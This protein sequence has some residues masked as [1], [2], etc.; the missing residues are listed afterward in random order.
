[1]TIVG[2]IAYSKYTMVLSSKVSSVIIDQIRDEARALFQLF[3]M[4]I[5]L[6]WTAGC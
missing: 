5:L 4:R 2:N 1:M 6:G 3:G